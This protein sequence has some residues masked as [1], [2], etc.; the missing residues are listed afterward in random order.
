MKVS[1]LTQG[2]VLHS[3]NEKLQVKYFSEAIKSKHQGNVQNHNL[4]IKKKKEKAIELTEAITNDTICID[5]NA[6]PRDKKTS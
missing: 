1:A 5:L 4:T 3:V 2:R 6:S